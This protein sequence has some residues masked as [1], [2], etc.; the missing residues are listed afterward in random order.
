MD[1]EYID[2]IGIESYS[3]SIKH[4]LRLNGELLTTG[5]NLPCYYPRDNKKST[6]TIQAQRVKH[7]VGTA[8]GNV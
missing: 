6:A 5:A 2:S 1:I 7:V 3:V 8:N 4:S